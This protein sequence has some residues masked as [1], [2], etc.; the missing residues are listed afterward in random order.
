MIEPNFVSYN[1]ILFYFG[2]Y[3]MA[4][5]DLNKSKKL[6]LNVNIVKQD[7]LRK[8]EFLNCGGSVVWK[9]GF[10]FLQI[11]DLLGKYFDA[12]VLVVE[13]KTF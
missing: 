7:L 11:L 13:V 2:I 3:N 5:V 8:K 10:K 4:R 12:E 1:T 6:P 9:Q